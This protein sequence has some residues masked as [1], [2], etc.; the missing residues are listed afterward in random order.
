MVRARD[1]V[2]AVRLDGGPAPL[3]Q[4]RVQH[5]D[6]AVTAEGDR[7]LADGELRFAGQLQRAVDPPHV[8]E[9]RRGGQSRLPTRE[10]QRL[11]GQVRHDQCRDDLLNGLEP[12]RHPGA[13]AFGG[14]LVDLSEQDRAEVRRP[15]EHPPPA[16]PLNHLVAEPTAE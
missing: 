12:G 16:Q 15:R 10:R 6:L 2:G 11:V 1:D 9:E 4:R 14:N 7:L 8:A 5:D 13:E 3:A